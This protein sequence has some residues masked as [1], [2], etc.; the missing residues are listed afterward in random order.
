MCGVHRTTRSPSSS[1]TS[2]NVVCVAGCCGPKFSVQRLPSPPFPNSLGNILVDLKKN[3]PLGWSAMEKTPMEVGWLGMLS[4]SPHPFATALFVAMHAMAGAPDGVMN[5]TVSGSTW[6]SLRFN[7]TEVG[8]TGINAALCG[9][10]GCP[11]LLVTGD[12]ASC[13]EGTA[14]LG[15]GLTTV[16]V[17]HG[18]SAYSARQIPP[19]RARALIEQGAKQALSDLSAVAP[20]D[21]GRPCEIAVEYKNTAAPDELRFRHGVERLDDRTIVSRADDWWTAWKQF[22]F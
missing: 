16:A 14:L 11:V 3:A 13:R 7:G 4:K 15:G 22:F 10:W 2:R 9:T 20:Y 19:V 1:S 6:R 12:E 8:E 5:H 17:K 21:P 18:L